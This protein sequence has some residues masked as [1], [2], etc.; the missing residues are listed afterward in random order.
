MN[1]HKPRGPVLQEVVLPCLKTVSVEHLMTESSPEGC[2]INHNFVSQ[3]LYKSNKLSTFS[4]IL[5]ILA[6]YTMACHRKIK[7]PNA[8]W[9]ANAN[10]MVNLHW[11]YQHWR[12]TYW[13]WRPSGIVQGRHLGPSSQ[14]RRRALHWGLP[15][16]RHSHSYST[17][18]SMRRYREPDLWSTQKI[19]H[20]GNIPSGDDFSQTQ[21]TN[22]FTNLLLV[23][24]CSL[25]LSFISFDSRLV[26]FSIFKQE[27]YY[28][29]RWRMFVYND[30]PFKVRVN[31]GKEVC[32]YTLEMLPNK[33]PNAFQIRKVHLSFELG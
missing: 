30:R 10:D 15:S 25:H 14:V 24:I 8:V 19:Q 28:C 3:D 23:L 7:V 13:C 16:H 17:Q 11:R 5:K 31:I 20:V 27:K 32:Y 33:I 6:M 18:F 2:W 9:K 21:L 12:L 29:R 22:A 26:N 1:L 4:N